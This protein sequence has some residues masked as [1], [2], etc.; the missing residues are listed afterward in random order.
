[1]REILRIGRARNIAM[2]EDDATLNR[3]F[4][5]VMKDLALPQ[6]RQVEMMETM[7]RKHKWTLIQMN[8]SKEEK[9]LY[10][11]HNPIIKQC[12]RTSF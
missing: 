3:L 11:C 2:P 5:L 12:H 10:K 9:G 8:K 1:M 4:H 7:S 6:A